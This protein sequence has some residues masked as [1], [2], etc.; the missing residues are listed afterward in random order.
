MKI[1]RISL[2]NLASLAGT[3]TVD[4][5]RDPLRSTGLFSIS[6]PT[7]SGKST[8]LDALCLALYEDTPRLSAAAGERLPDA[9]G[10]ITQKD[11]GNLL[12]RGAAEGFAEV[13]FV[14]VD[15]GTYTARWSIRRARLH[16]DGALQKT[17]IVLYRGNVF[18][19]NGGQV[20]Q[21]G[22]KAEVQPAIAEKVGLSFSQFTRAVLLA[23]NDF[24]VFLKAGDRERALILQALT[25]SERFERWSMAVFNRDK[26]ETE[27]VQTIELQLKGQAPLSPELRAQ[28]EAAQVAAFERLN[29]AQAKVSERETHVAWFARQRELTADDARAT[30]RHAEAARKLAEAAPRQAELQ[31]SGEIAREAR[32]LYDAEQQAIAQHAAAIKAQSEAEARKV[33]SAKEAAAATQLHDVAKAAY[34]AAQ[35]AL[36]AAGPV[37]ARARVLDAQ[38]EP[39]AKQLETAT[40]DCKTAEMAWKSIEARVEHGAADLKRRRGAHAPLQADREPLAYL[41]PVVA[42]ASAW[43]DRLLT[44]FHAKQE[45]DKLQAALVT[46]SASAAEIVNQLEQLRVSTTG[47]MQARAEAE[48]K[49]QA[50]AEGL[51]SFDP[52]LLATERRALDV[53]HGV[54]TDA[55]GQLDLLVASIAQSDPLRQEL[56]NL[57]AAVAAHTAAL[58]EL[59]AQ[60]LQ[61]AEAA[62]KAASDARANAEAAVDKA[63]GV[64]RAGLLLQQPC[65][66]CGSLEHP[67][68]RHAPV[69]DAALEAVRAAE[70]QNR[71]ALDTL[72]REVVERET[73][74]KLSSTAT[75]EKTAAL[76]ELE[77]RQ[78]DLRK[79]AFKAAIAAEWAKLAEV[80]ALAAA[81]SELEKHGKTRDSL[82]EREGK[83]RAAA[84]GADEARKRFD[85]AKTATE[86]AEKKMAELGAQQTGA[87][88][89]VTAAHEQVGRAE[90][91]FTSA[92]GALTPLF[93]ALP[94]TAR[95]DFAADA[96]ALIARFSAET[97]KLA[98][99]EQ[100]IS[101]AAQAIEKA[102]VAEEAVRREFSAATETLTK[103]RITESTARHAHDKVKEERDGL[104]GGRTVQTE[105][106]ALFASV[107]K[108]K[109]AWDG[110]ASKVTEVGKFEAAVIEAQAG[111]GRIL[112]ATA[113][114]QVAAVKMLDSWL[115]AFA[116][117]SDRPLDRATLRQV[118]G[119]DE[120]WYRAERDFLESL[121]K[122]DSIATGEQSAHRATLAAHIAA[123][124][125]TEEEGTIA[126]DLTQRRQLKNEAEKQHVTAA[127]VIAADDQRRV[128][129]ATLLEQLTAQQS[130]A[131]P[132]GKLNELI[133]SSDGAK[134]RGIAQRYTLDLL[135]GYANAQLDLLSARYRLER[136]PESLNLIVVDREMADER[137]SV[138]SLSGGESFLVSLALALGLAS[139]TSNRIRIESLF[140]DEGFGSLDQET[141]NTAMGALMQLEAQGRKVGVISHVTEMADAI[142]VQIRVVKGRAGTSQLVV[143]GMETDASGPMADV[144]IA[145][146]PSVATATDAEIAALA[147]R[148]LGLL[149]REKQSGQDFVSTSSLRKEMGCELKELTAARVLLGNQVVLEGKSLG[150]A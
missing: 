5:T 79:K 75:Q 78:A 138:H 25:G 147:Q 70:K 142:P 17:E 49:C 130:K 1:L 84:K 135:L 58:A 10:A 19:G 64:L 20:L 92:S 59:K 131:A 112:K 97:K 34:D 117:R 116:A 125:T 73:A 150:M 74:L 42:E 87:G 129:S 43:R 133:G 146:A 86:V 102:V 30:E 51:R 77:K 33:Q 32:P 104:L 62:W 114:Q 39:L 81:A 103:S 94:A 145:A 111:T 108:S 120:L 23:Q 123:R 107:E 127:A 48:A 53:T 119:R 22:K 82:T 100:Q 35:N 67:F 11:P 121:A 101:E 29:A 44:T 4:F 9:G 54:L 72:S 24:A 8:L 140:I 148:L 60:K 63:V 40:Q 45:R 143:P 141:L 66:V 50:A 46:K 115:E 128:S 139:L 88:A 124:P 149:Q 89:A 110:A 65:P 15:G 126:A 76:A 26:I 3:Q 85:T 37:M 14:G 6:G 61:V 55:H 136:L 96:Q 38:L 31:R 99:L 90:S 132:W 27:A 28:A 69:V 36:A 106:A 109:K 95:T 13:A 144:A 113:E 105:E 68:S 57:A 41:S 83:H 7:G 12:R 91:A 21:G 56:K 71:E 18:N 80:D 122:A 118:L 52:D 137:R 16:A 134:F 98:Q 47:L 2:R 93:A